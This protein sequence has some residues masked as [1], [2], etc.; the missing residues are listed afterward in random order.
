MIHHIEFLLDYFLRSETQTSATEIQFKLCGYSARQRLSN[1]S[2]SYKVKQLSEIY[3]LFKK[4]G[5]KHI[6]TSY[7]IALVQIFILMGLAKDMESTKL[8]LYILKPELF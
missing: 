5:L 8:I 1:L 2:Y 4:I 7:K 3:L 6:Q